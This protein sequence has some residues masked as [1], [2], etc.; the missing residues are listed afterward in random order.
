MSR[1]D[2]LKEAIAGDARLR[3]APDSVVIDYELPSSDGWVVA[4]EFDGHGPRDRSAITRRTR[5]YQGLYALSASGDTWT[6][7]AN[8]VGGAGAA[9][10][11]SQVW[12]RWGGFGEVRGGWVADPRGVQVRLTDRDAR[13]VTGDVTNGVA[14]LTWAPDGFGEVAMTELVDAA[15]HVIARDRTDLNPRPTE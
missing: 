15:G 1:L 6:I 4:A 8:S 7:G 12:S 11:R 9:T 3:V 5:R 2:A 13:T 14:I 10:Q